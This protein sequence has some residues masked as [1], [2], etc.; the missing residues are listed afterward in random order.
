MGMFYQQASGYDPHIAVCADALYGSFLQRPQQF[1]AGDQVARRIVV[2]LIE[3]TPGKTAALAESVSA[4]AGPKGRML[5]LK[6]PE[7]GQTAV[8]LL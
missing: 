5:H 8:L 2:F 4:E 3:V 6:L 7:G 1:K